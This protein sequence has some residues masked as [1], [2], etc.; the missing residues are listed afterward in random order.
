M[1]KIQIGGQGLLNGVAINGKN[2]KA[3]ATREKNNNISLSFEKIYRVQEE[4][5]LRAFPFFRGILIIFDT[6]SS[7]VESLDILSNDILNSE[8]IK[9]KKLINFLAMILAFLLFIFTFLVIPVL[10]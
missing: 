6:V 2:S 8:E 1:G 9:N 7:G 10:I 3:I 5:G 4:T